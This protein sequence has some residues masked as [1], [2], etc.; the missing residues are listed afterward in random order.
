MHGKDLSKADCSVNI[1][2]YLLAQETQEPVKAICSIGDKQVNI[3][4]QLVDFTTIINKAHEYIKHIG[5]FEK[6]AEWGLQ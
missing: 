2:C 6:L 1:Y 4:G 5:G 3:N